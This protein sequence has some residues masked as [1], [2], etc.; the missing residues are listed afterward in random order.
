MVIFC[1]SGQ[2]RQACGDD[3]ELEGF[4][5]S[6]TVGASLMHTDF[7]VQAFHRSTADLV[8][9]MA[10]GGDAFPVITDDVEMALHVHSW[11]RARAAVQRVTVDDALR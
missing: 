5:V 2:R 10:V 8:L 1:T 11:S 4:L 3:L 6:I 7:V 9:G